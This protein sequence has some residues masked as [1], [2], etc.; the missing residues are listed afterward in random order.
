MGGKGRRV[1]GCEVEVGSGCETGDF[2]PE[3]ALMLVRI[4]I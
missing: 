2:V 4:T 1:G 3:Y